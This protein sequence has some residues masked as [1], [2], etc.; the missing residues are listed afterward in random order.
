MYIYIPVKD[1]SNI[2]KICRGSTY[3][4]LTATAAATTVVRCIMGNKGPSLEGDKN[5]SRHLERTLLDT[6]ELEQ[7]LGC[8]WTFQKKARTQVPTG[9]Q[10]NS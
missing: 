9:T 2:L 6:N 4:L 7:Y 3:Y 1:N 5:T 8:G 10:I